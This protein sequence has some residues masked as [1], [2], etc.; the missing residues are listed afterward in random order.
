MAE[1]F[2]EVY[3]QLVG[4]KDFPKLSNLWKKDRAGGKGYV[5]SGFM[6][7]TDETL[8]FNGE[9][10]ERNLPAKLSVGKVRKDADGNPEKGENGRDITDYT[11]LC[12][13]ELRPSNIEPGT[14]IFFGTDAD[15]N[16]YVVKYCAPKKER[17]PRDE[18][19][20]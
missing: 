19:S 15:G 7:D 18:A 13:L 3:R 11:E 16:K 2:M 5:V 10:K 14:N 9:W 20:F 4:Q 1:A 8:Y 12:T 17:Q 6:K